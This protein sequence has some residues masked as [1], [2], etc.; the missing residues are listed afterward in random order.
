M[1]KIVIASLISVWFSIRNHRW[2]A[3]NLSFLFNLS[4]LALLEGPAPL[5]GRLRW[6]FETP[7]LLCI[8]CLAKACLA[9]AV[10]SLARRRTAYCLSVRPSVRPCLVRQLM[11]IALLLVGHHL[12][13]YQGI[14]SSCAN[15][16]IF[17]LACPPEIWGAS[18]NHIIVL[19]IP[20][21]S[22]PAASIHCLLLSTSD[23]TQWMS[24]A[25]K[26]QWWRDLLMCNI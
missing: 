13:H 26:R 17:P 10:H 6:L 5:L 1:G 16:N 24:P 18:K 23:V 22:S 20:T 9:K 8:Y 3:L 12:E 2:K 14:C 4:D 21:S 15:Q 25:D 11:V 19:W 7:L